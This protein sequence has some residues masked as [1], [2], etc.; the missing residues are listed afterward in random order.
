MELVSALLLIVGSYLLGAIPWGVVIGR[1]FYSGTD[2]REHGSKSTGATNAYRVF[3]AKVSGSV[4]LLDAFKGVVPVVVA[5]A[6]DVDWWVVGAVALA[7]VIG[8]CWS[9]FIGFTGGKGVATGAGAIAAM[10]PWALVVLPLVVII[11]WV[12]RY[13]SLASLTC[14]ALAAVLVTIGAATD[15]APVEAAVASIL[16]CVVIFERHRGNIQR[17]RAGTERRLQRRSS[18]PA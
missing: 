8:H 14:S 15:R 1:L 12:T 11:I 3:G 13:V 10:A 16:I 17:L 7:S 9:I 5:R 18:V 4:F 6:L 2:L